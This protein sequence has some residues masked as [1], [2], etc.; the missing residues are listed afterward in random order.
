M[1]GGC[2]V[3]DPEVESVTTFLG[4]LPGLSCCGTS[5]AGRGTRLSRIEL[6]ESWV[7]DPEVEFVTTFLGDLP[8][9]SCCGTSS[10]G[11]D[12]GLSRIELEESYSDQFLA[13]R[14]ENPHLRHCFFS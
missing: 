2:W 3:G 8:G 5:S 12:T 1:C 4:D 10:A 7:G 11:R 6:E 13:G 9:L 14:Y